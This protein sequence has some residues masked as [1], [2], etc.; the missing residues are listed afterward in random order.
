L[1]SQASPNDSEIVIVV[2]IIVIGEAHLVLHNGGIIAQTACL[3]R[4]FA[5]SFLELCSD[6]PALGLHKAMTYMKLPKAVACIFILT[7]LYKEKERNYQ[8]TIKDNSRHRRLVMNVRTLF[9]Q[10]MF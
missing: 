1:T 3:D 4:V 5:V 6:Q 2:I 7:S 9:T 8:G 10:R